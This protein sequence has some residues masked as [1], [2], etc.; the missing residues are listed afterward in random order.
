MRKL[1]ISIIFLCLTT[2]NVTMAQVDR[3]KDLI[4]K[5]IDEQ[6]NKLEILYKK[7]HQH[8]ELSF[9]EIET[10]KV[11]VQE[12]KNAG[13]EVTANFGGNSI[14]GILRNGNGPVIML[15]TDMDALPILEKTGLPYAS[16]VKAIN[17]SGNEVPVMHAC[18]HD[19]HMT[20]FTGIINT[21]SMLKKEWKGTLIAIAQQA[22]ERNGGSIEMIKAGLYRK[23][24]V[25]DF[26]FAYHV[27]SNL[28]AGKIGF[29]P[30]PAF[31]NVDDVDITVYGKGGHGAYP[32]LTKDPVVMAS[33]IVLDLQTIVS[34]EIS[35]LS[36]AVVTVGTIHG[37]TQRN[38]I[39]DEVKLSLTI[40]TYTEDVRKQIFEAIKRIATG[41][42]LSA[43]MPE[44]K[45][46]L[47]E[48]GSDPTPSVDNNPA[49]TNRV[50]A[51]F[52]KIVGDENIVQVPPEMVG[53]DFGLYGKTDPKVPIFLAWLGSAN[54]ELI[55]S[56]NEKGTIPP[57]LHSPEFAPEPEKTIRTGVLAMSYALIN[58]FNKK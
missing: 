3:Q 47:V 11:M 23:F 52:R 31:A 34:R 1:A 38:I 27:R 18:G 37:G 58:L 2:F 53:E 30:G 9:Q 13:F 17:A 10:S 36:P 7:L 40:R 14:V 43:G 33:R 42:A 21:L 46:P 41:V 57:P 26:A 54:P 32:H 19:M 22:E 20:V 15:R 55:K 24:P 4:N 25:P 29:C 49:L 35:P 48:I 39:P 8:P 28:E 6:Y 12:L 5:Q 56:C 16:S 50:V 51:E 45:M 44:D